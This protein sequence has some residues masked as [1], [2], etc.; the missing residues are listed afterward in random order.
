MNVSRKDIYD[1]RE[2]EEVEEVDDGARAMLEKM[3]SSGWS[4]A[5]ETQVEEKEDEKMEEDKP[6]E[7]PAIC[8]CDY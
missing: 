7:T 2:D 6:E 8:E 3:L 5:V 1:E 4:N